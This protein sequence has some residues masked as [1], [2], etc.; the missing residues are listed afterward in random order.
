[1]KGTAKGIGGAVVK[2]LSGG[3]DLLMKTTEGVHNMVK[4]GGRRNKK[5]KKEAKAL[6][7]R[8]Q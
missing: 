8:S 4:V 2:P 5:D 7:S 6:T 3:L 1:M